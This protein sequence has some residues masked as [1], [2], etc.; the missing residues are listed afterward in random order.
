MKISI[1]II[2]LVLMDSTSNLLIAK[3][4]KQVG[5]I[6]TTQPQKLLRIVRKLA[7]SPSIWLGF[8]FQACTFFLLLTLL[9]WANLSLVIP[10]ASSGYVVN[11]LG[12][13]FLLKEK[14]AKERWLG[15]LLI[16]AGVALVSLN[17]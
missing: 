6:S 14:V 3:G 17:K 10:L 7:K 8:L 11:M 5:E 13:R 4:M 16:G 15:T 2:L 1:A 9:S 12:A